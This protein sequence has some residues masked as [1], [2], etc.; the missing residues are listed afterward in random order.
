MRESEAG[1]LLTLTDGVMAEFDQYK[2]KY[3]EIIE[4]SIR[5][6]GKSHDF[7]TKAKADYF[8]GLLRK[9]HPDQRNI[10]LLD[11]GCGHGAIHPFVAS[12]TGKIT[13]IDTAGEV[14]ELAKKQNPANDYFVF[15][16]ARI[17]A[18]DRSFDAALMICVMHHVPPPQW[19]GLLKEARRVL[20]PG[21][22]LT[23]FEHNPLNPLTQYVVRSNVIDK[24]AMLLRKG[25]LERLMR[26]AGFSTLESRFILLTPFDNP[27][28][29]Q[30]EKAMGAIPLG[31]QYYVSGQ[32]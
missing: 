2:D 8:I 26:E 17:A 31:A 18:A 14:I 22:S 27:I 13:G 1:S 25:L 24:D 30:I 12:S 4:R 29:R 23:V 6:G 7:Y 28:A 32:A 11:I 16:G 15:D 20:A 9:L 3:E 21:G 10:S 5:I 19:V